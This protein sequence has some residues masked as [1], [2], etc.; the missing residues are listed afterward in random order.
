M[1]S[2]A[3]TEECQDTNQ[4]HPDYSNIGSTSNATSAART[5]QGAATLIDTYFDSIDKAGRLDTPREDAAAA[6]ALGFAKAVAAGSARA[7]ADCSISTASLTMQL[8][9]QLGDSANS[10]NSRADAS[11]TASVPA[12]I[13]FET[14]QQQIVQGEDSRSLSQQS[15]SPRAAP[16]TLK[17]AAVPQLRLQ[18]QQT[19]SQW[20]NSSTVSSPGSAAATVQQSCS[21]Q[22]E[23]HGKCSALPLLGSMSPRAGGSSMD[24]IL[25]ISSP[26]SNRLAYP[27]DMLESPATAAATVPVHIQQRSY[28]Q[29]A[30][31]LL[32][33]STRSQHD[34]AAAATMFGALP[35]LGS[36]RGTWASQ[37]GCSSS[38]STSSNSGAAYLKLT[39]RVLAQEPADPVPGIIL[40]PWREQ[41]QHTCTD[42]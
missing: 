35:A 25:K 15:K 10:R 1:Q 38:N 26:S 2:T 40:A 3:A 14:A 13:S 6:V 37:G 5:A 18:Q 20:F 32:L 24:D 8:A 22:Y 19:G 4:L 17:R 42:M 30:P 23:Q 41:Q 39:A 36:P 27:G 29:Y 16:L 28:Q 9:G 31:G 34:Q 21:A 12:G 11:L 33:S 7:T